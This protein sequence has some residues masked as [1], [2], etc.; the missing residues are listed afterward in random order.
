MVKRLISLFTRK[1]QCCDT[2]YE[3]KLMAALVV[4]P[5][6]F[7]SYRIENIDTKLHRLMVT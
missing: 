6:F 5:F 3:K 4:P 7:Y 2:L 1:R